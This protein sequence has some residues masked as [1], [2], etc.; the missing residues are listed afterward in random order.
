MMMNLTE[1]GTLFEDGVCDFQY[2]NSTFLGLRITPHDCLFAVLVKSTYYLLSIETQW[3]GG[4]CQCFVSQIFGPSGI[5]ILFQN[6][7]HDR[8][9]HIGLQT[10]RRRCRH[11]RYD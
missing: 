11:Q 10:A 2:A 4:F 7:R 3:H 8:H 9:V 1:D 6:E 5:A